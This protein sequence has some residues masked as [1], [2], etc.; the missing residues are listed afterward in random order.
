[1]NIYNNVKDIKQDRVVLLVEWQRWD[2]SSKGRKTYGIFP[3]VEERLPYKWMSTNHYVTQFLT[4]HGDFADKLAKLGI[5]RSATCACGEEQETAEHV[6]L[7]CRMFKE[8]RNSEKNA[9]ITR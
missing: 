5:R 2:Q 1:M 6:L 3:N 4:G 7:H 8:E 9:K